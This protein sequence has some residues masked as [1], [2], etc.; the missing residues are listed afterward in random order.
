MVTSK[1]SALEFRRSEFGITK[2][3]AGRVPWD[4]ALGRR[5]AHESWLRVKYYF[6]QAQRPFISTRRKSGKMPG[7]LCG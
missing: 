2:D 1:L 7:S 4:K 5:E 3:L 6:L